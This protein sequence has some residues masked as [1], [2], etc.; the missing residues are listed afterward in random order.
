MIGFWHIKDKVISLAVSIDQRQ[1]GTRELHT[2][3]LESD[4]GQSE[5]TAK[6]CH[7]A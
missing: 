6:F 2:I 3:R 7:R 5:A 4:R 1:A